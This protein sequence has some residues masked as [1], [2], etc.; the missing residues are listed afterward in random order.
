MMKSNRPAFAL[1][2]V[3]AC[4]L[5]TLPNTVRAQAYAEV[6]DAGQTLA[7][8]ANTVTVGPTLTTI[9][10]T[11]SSFTDA[12]LF[13][14]VITNTMTFSATASSLQGIDTALFLF[15]SLGAAVVAND[16]QSNL[17]FQ[18]AI[19]AGS[20]FVMTLSPGTYYLGISLS[21]NE[22]INSNSQLLFTVDSPTTAVRGPAGG[23]NPTTLSTFNG[24]TFF[25]E[26]GVY[27]IALTGSAAVP[28]PSTWALG[29][30]G[31]ALLSAFVLRRRASQ[32]LNA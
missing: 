19:P 5:L 6:G 29:I 23:L 8:A 26:S 2:A 21:G 17:S 28:E 11:L 25:N 32:N 9:T 4:L 1:S 7:T 20:S 12:D 30:V 16:D 13:K 14:F 22:P 18:A 10:G 31:S 15:N 27:S 3:A 24:N